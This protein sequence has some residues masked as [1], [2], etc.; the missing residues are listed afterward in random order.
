MTRSRTLRGY[1]RGAVGILGP[2]GP[3]DVP[4]FVGAG[5]SRRGCRCPDHAD[6]RRAGG[7][8]SPPA[9]P[10]G[11]QQSVGELLGRLRHQVL[12]ERPGPNV[13][14][15]R[16][17]VDGTIRT[18][19]IPGDV[20]GERMRVAPLWPSQVSDLARIAPAGGIRSL[21][22]AVGNA[23]DCRQ[24]NRRH[25][26]QGPRRQLLTPDH[27]E[28]RRP[29]AEQPGHDMADLVYVCALPW[30]AT[31]PRWLPSLAELKQ[32]RETVPRQASDR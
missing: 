31:C 19:I 14:G 30:L 9:G 32:L 26:P 16:T 25:D 4:K 22:I 20:N 17:S 18:Y 13:W 15:T 1:R 8:S 29:G 3:R 23:E 24:P 28:H 21:P 6:R 5:D 12:G 11:S 10:Q 27:R 7:G 2:V